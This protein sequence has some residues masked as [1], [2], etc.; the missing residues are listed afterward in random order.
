[1]TTGKVL[2]FDLKK[3]FGFIRALNQDIFV[4]YS[5]IIAPDGEFK[6]LS[7]GDL[8]EFEIFQADRGGGQQKIQAKNVKVLKEGDINAHQ[9]NHEDR[10]VRRHHQRPEEDSL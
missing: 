3:G 2:W 7:E 9:G 10:S 1:M 5:K 6:T 8:V 4:H